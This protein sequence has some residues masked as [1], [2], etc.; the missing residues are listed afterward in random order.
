MPFFAQGE[1]DQ[2]V[3]A[4]ELGALPNAFDFHLV[5]GGS[6]KIGRFESARIRDVGEELLTLVIHESI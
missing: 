5:F 6:G 3:K 4:Q 2:I 1:L